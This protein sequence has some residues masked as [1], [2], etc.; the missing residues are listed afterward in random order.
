[1]IDEI[2]DEIEKNLMVLLIVFRMIEVGEIF[3]L[4]LVKFVGGEDK[5]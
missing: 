5:L 3:E 1:M 4:I 2:I